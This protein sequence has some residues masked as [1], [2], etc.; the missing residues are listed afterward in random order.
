MGIG[1]DQGD[2]E[3]VGGGRDLQ[4]PVAEATEE[5]GPEVRGLRVTEGHPEDLS[6]ALTADT[7]G[8]HESVR[9]DAAAVADVEVGGVQEQVREPGVIDPAVQELMHRLVDLGTDP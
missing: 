6:P 1:R 3:G 5:L 9:D 7:G 4:P 2:A 8:N